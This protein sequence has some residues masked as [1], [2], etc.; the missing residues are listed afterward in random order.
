MPRP[1]LIALVAF[2]ATANLYGQE[3]KPSPAVK[4]ILEDTARKVRTNR[5]AFDKA[6][7][8][9]LAEARKALEELSTKLIKDGK[10]EDA[11]VVLKQV[12]TL[13]ADV[14]RMANAPAPV[15]GGAGPQKPLFER[16]AGRWRSRDGKMACVI[17]ENGNFAD[18]WGDR[19]EIKEKGKLKILGDG[20]AEVL[21][22]NG[23]KIVIRPAGDD[24]LAMLAWTERGFEDGDGRIVFRERR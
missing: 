4:R 12:K 19:E 6:N 21:L 14:M 1:L 10:A 7:E 2:V 8:K 20:V 24:A 23:W 16:M 18:F 11:T 13:D 3:P 15:A 5:Q 22:T 17:D 9:P